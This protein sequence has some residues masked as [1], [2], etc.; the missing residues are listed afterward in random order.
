M[1]EGF[2]YFLPLC[3]A[4][5]RVLIDQVEKL[6]ATSLETISF[7]AVGNSVP[8]DLADMHIKSFMHFHS[9]LIIWGKNQVKVLGQNWAHFP[10]SPL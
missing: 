10:H 4:V 5:G 1:Y 3:T 2:H 9:S 7:S 6:G 8:T